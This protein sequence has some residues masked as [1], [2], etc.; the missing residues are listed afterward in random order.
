MKQ[1]SAWP[2][3]LALFFGSLALLYL[4]AAELGYARDEG[5]YFVAARRYE[6]WFELVATK[7]AAAFDRA[8]VDGAWVANHEHPGLMK[9]LFALSHR[10]LHTKMGLIA[11]PGTSFRFPSMVLSAAMVALVFRWVARHYGARAGLVA[12]LSLLFMPRVFYQ[13]HLACFDVPITF[14]FLAVFFGYARSLERPGIAWPVATGALYGCAL[15]TKHNAWF[16]PV[17]LVVHAALLLVL[18]WSSRERL[19]PLVK[20]AGA[21]LGAM[22]L[23]GPLV[24]LASWPWLWFDTKRRFLEYADFHLNH[25]YYNMEFLGQTYFQPPFPRL[26]APTMF[27][28]TVSLVTILAALLAVILGLRTWLATLNQ[29]LRRGWLGEGAPSLVDRRTSEEL[30]L[31]LL[32]VGISFG[33]WVF[34]TT[35]IFGGTKH[36]MPAYPFV[37]MLAGAGFQRVARLF[38][39][40]ARRL[41]WPVRLRSLSQVVLLACFVAAPMRLAYAGHPWGLSLYTPI[42]G[43]AQGAASLGLN[44]T[45]WG[46]TSQSVMDDVAKAAPTGA[47]IYPHDTARASWEMLRE[48]GRVGRSFEAVWAPESADYSLYHHEQ[49]MAVQ[50]YQMWVAYGTV[51]PW[52]VD[53]PNGVPVI[54]VYQNPQRRLAR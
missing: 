47:K 2:I 13:A 37:A 26:Y 45:F 35:P 31:W 42:V 19:A 39:V 34:D 10:L 33:P 8:A 28:A 29:R 36:W 9:S 40:G 53:G 15:A 4:T 14:W 18:R 22:A 43:G 16:L 11:E 24:F 50:E 52:L 7:R 1:R 20:R 41:R 32:G 38:M 30:L 48:D 44:R 12:A 54:F 27:V 25:V 5:F 46:Y 51:R 21:A 49:H 17:A 6:N 3:A 23:L